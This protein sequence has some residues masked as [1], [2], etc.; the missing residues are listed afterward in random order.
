MQAA[1]D[2]ATNTGHLLELSEA[3]WWQ[4]VVPQIDE[5]V[6][7]ADQPRGEYERYLQDPERPALL[8]ALRDATRSA[9]AAIEDSLDA[10][11][12]QPMTGPGPSPRCFTAAWEKNRPRRGARRGPGLSARPQD[13]PEPIREHPECSTP[14]RPS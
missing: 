3:F 1:Q 10:I 13:A 9:A 2:Y 11:T 12:A 5:T 6:R 8:Q 7:R 4:D 14:G